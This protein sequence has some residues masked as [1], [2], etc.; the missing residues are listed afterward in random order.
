M[1]LKN[2]ILII[3]VSG[4][5]LF[6][7][8]VGCLPKMQI[9]FSNNTYKEVEN[10][11]DMYIMQAYA[12]LDLKLH[13][14]AKENLTKAYKLTQDKAYLK[15]IIGILMFK[16]EWNEA[17]KIAL[18][19]QKKYPKDEEMQQV[20]IEILGNMGDFRA[21]NQEIQDL[22]KQD[23]SAQNLEIASS[24][25]FL[26]NDYQKAIAYL[27]ESY[28][29]SGN[30]QIANKL[31]SIYLLF[32]KDK[33]KA[34]GVYEEHIKKYGISQNIGERLALVYLE[35][36]KVLDA[37]RIYQNL[38]KAT[39]DSKYA[40]FVLEIYFKG[41]Y[42]N[43]ARKFLEQ[44]PNIQ[45]RDEFLLEIYRLTKEHKKAIALLQK[46]YTENGNVDY[47]ALEAMLIYE[48][49][50]NRNNIILLRQV[51]N[52][53][54]EVVKKSNNAL[55]WNYYGYLLIDHSLDIKKG[56]QCVQEALKQEPK[57]PYFLD[58]LAWGYYKL[59]DCKNA[60]IVIGE[61][62]QEDIQKEK[63]ISEHFKLIQQCKIQ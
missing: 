35:E 4:I 17:K 5:C 9:D 12:A 10:L 55:Y 13:D 7:V 34:I 37:A 31:A 38:Y 59:N 1:L 41:N 39:Y 54:E 25:Y 27:R 36:K 33:N 62:A 51:T 60:Q 20:L 61:I 19:Y 45:S 43:Q 26:Q 49:A 21:A 11:E 22:L 29:L 56:M 50:Q 16:K 47:L 53:F 40:R 28:L 23:R 32:L 63:E 44:N 8:L 2:K 42:F 15:E 18:E 52:K 58:S 14:L 6:L 24:I 46:L 57:N 30:E 48:N 3:L